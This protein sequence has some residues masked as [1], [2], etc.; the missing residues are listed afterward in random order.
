MGPRG[1]ASAGNVAAGAT[2]AGVRV[3]VHV[4]GLARRFRW[5]HWPPPDPVPLLIRWRPAFL[6]R[7]A[8]NGGTPRRILGSAHAS[9]HADHTRRRTPRM[10]ARMPARPLWSGPGRT[11]SAG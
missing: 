7:P 6:R 4:H 8:D 9:A 5:R 10:P 1:E 2:V 11:R 3:A